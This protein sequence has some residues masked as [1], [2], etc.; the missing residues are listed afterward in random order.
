MSPCVQQ[1]VLSPGSVYDAADGPLPV[2]GGHSGAS[3]AKPSSEKTP[4]F[5]RALLADF[6]PLPLSTHTT[7]KLRVK[8]TISNWLFGFTYKRVCSVRSPVNND[9]RPVA[10][11][12][13]SPYQITGH[14]S[15]ATPSHMVLE[16]FKM[17]LREGDSQVTDQGHR[18]KCDRR[19]IFPIAHNKKRR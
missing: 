7:C 17:P 2:L 18:Q 4:T 3:G 8:P 11:A 5:T 16:R 19:G 10:A 1:H 14:D 6:R 13:S 12:G 9:T 15:R